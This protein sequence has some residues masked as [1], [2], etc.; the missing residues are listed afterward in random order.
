[1]S[2]GEDVEKLE[3]RKLLVGVKNGVVTL[4]NSLA[5]I[6]KGYHRHSNSTHI[7]KQEN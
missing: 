5:V 2:I 3:S 7:Y 6:Q 4:E 1:M